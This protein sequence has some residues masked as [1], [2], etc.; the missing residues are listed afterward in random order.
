MSDKKDLEKR[1]ES[2][3]SP[4]GRNLVY[5]IVI[6]AGVLLLA[7]SGYSIYSKYAGDKEDRE[8]YNTL[9]DRFLNTSKEKKEK[10]FNFEWGSG[11]GSFASADTIWYKRV[12]V[13][14]DGLNAINEDVVGWI[15]FE[16]EDISYPLLYSEEVDYYIRRTLYGDYATSGSVFIDERNSPDLEDNL[17]IVYGHNMRN[18]SMF[19]RL[20]RFRDE[21]DYYDDHQYFQILTEGGKAYR[22]RVFAYFEFDHSEVEVADPEFY[23]SEDPATAVT[24]YEMVD[25]TTEWREQGISESEILER[26]PVT[27][28]SFIANLEH[29]YE[30]YLDAV[31]SRSMRDTG[32]DV[33]TDDKIAALYTCS[34]SGTSD[35]RL[36][37][38]GVRVAEHDFNEQTKEENSDIYTLDR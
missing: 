22:Y 26:D 13:D 5:D 17:T 2:R 25:R 36:M 18:S 30:S 33:T 16:N 19:G 8:M 24:E 15:Y 21:E 3:L 23:D 31:Q 11:D 6:I 12:S 9:N 20:R 37:V 14:F 32:I 34:S 10:S 28:R 4:K 29:T 27:E 35:G 1:P 38:Y 7:G